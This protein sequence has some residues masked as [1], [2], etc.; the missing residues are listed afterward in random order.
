L[1]VET[2]VGVAGSGRCRNVSPS[3][4]LRGAAF[5]YM[6]WDKLRMSTPAVV[7]TDVFLVAMTAR[8]GRLGGARTTL[9][10]G[11]R[12]SSSSDGL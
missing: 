4:C 11:R 3:S 2:V 1:V 8:A 9:I 5:L 6:R 7:G 10:P 12:S